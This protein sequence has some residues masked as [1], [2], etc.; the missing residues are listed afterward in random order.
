MRLSIRNFLRITDLY[1]LLLKWKLSLRCV[2]GD[3]C[4]IF[5]IFIDRFFKKVSLKLLL[6]SEL[7]YISLSILDNFNVILNSTLHQISKDYRI[8]ISRYQNFYKLTD[9][10]SFQFKYS[11]SLEIWKLKETRRKL[12]KSISCFE[13]NIYFQ[14]IFTSS[15]YCSFNDFLSLICRGGIGEGITN[16]G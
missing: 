12:K 5:L 16:R 10:S 15:R 11:F 4:I 3:R 1:F 13:W 6:L 14:K 9:L 7:Y 2:P 8:D